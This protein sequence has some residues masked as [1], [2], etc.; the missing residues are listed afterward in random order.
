L[1]IVRHADLA[2]A[3]GRMPSGLAEATL[4]ARAADGSVVLHEQLTA[5][6]VPD[7]LGMDVTQAIRPG[8]LAWWGGTELQL[9]PDAAP[10][11]GSFEGYVVVDQEPAPG[12]RDLATGQITVVGRRSIVGSLA[13][14]ATGIDL[15]GLESRVA[16]HRGSWSVIVFS[17]RDCTPCD[18]VR[19]AL[20]AWERSTTG[21]VTTV[22]I[23]R[24]TADYLT[25][26]NP[27]AVSVT[28][29]VYVVGP[30][31]RVRAEYLG[32]TRDIVSSIAATIALG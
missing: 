7:L 12:T 20:E 9:L 32:P 21:E 13:P 28:P 6:A 1:G 27:Y 14:D 23:D 16:D 17:A 4:E 18:E 3:W 8:D 19:S 11:G 31:G 22:E 24:N 2:L 30:D 5:R 10:T 29:T 26:L 15:D 25:V